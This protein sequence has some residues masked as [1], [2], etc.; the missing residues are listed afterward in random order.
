M[1]LYLCFF[2]YLLLHHWMGSGVK[3]G[4]GWLDLDPF[5]IHQLVQD[6]GSWFHFYQRRNLFC[7]DG[8]QDGFQTY[9]LLNVKCNNIGNSSRLSESEGKDFGQDSIIKFLVCLRYCPY[10]KIIYLIPWMI[11]VFHCVIHIWILII[12]WSGQILW[13]YLHL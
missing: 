4:W 2:E 6:L 9:K 5:S 11:G 7:H 10:V 13:I 1:Q 12:I 8:F 3:E